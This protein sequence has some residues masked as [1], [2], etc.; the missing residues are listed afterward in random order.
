MS[1]EEKTWN[2]KKHTDQRRKR[3]AKSLASPTKM[4]EVRR[5]SQAGVE[6]TSYEFLSPAGQPGSNR[7]ERLANRAKFKRA[8]R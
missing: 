3:P 8:N 7:A 1:Y 6:Y 4:I 5:K 2:P